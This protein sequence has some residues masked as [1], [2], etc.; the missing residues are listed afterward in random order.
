MHD[1]QR[2]HSVSTRFIR[3]SIVGGVATSSLLLLHIPSILL[4]QAPQL[5]DLPVWVLK[6][7]MLINPLF[8]LMI[9]ALLGAVCAHRVGL[10]SLLAGSA[11]SSLQPRCVSISLIA[12]IIVAVVLVGLDHWSM[13]YLAEHW[14]QALTAQDTVPALSKLIVGLLYGGIAEEIML[15]W[16]LMSLL[17]WLC[18]ACFKLTR[19]CSAILCILSTSLLFGIGHLPNLALYADLDTAIVLRTV[20][21]NALAGSVYG[22]L[23][24]RYHLEAAILA[25]MT[26][27]IGFFIIGILLNG[28]L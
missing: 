24:F 7:M 17:L 18:L 23:F 22:L 16:G 5:N 12:G 3:L 20:L 8:M 25:H 14:Q 27:H 13:L 10:S 1:H 11:Q 4:E 19:T 21:L 9:A 15:R 26:T 6:L 2:S 28:A